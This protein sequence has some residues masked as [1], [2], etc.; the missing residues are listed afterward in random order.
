[1][2]TGAQ[3]LA[4]VH[5]WVLA[6]FPDTGGNILGQCHK[7]GARGLWPSQMQWE[8]ESDFTRSSASKRKVDLEYENSLIA[9]GLYDGGAFAK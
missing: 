4:C 5:H 3:N 7:C 8:L 2:A 9:Y 1:M 6:S